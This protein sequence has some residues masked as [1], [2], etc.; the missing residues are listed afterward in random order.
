MLDL[1][2]LG[3]L[4]MPSPHLLVLLPLPNGSTTYNLEL[5]LTRI[6]SPLA[7]LPS[8]HAWPKQ[9]FHPPIN[10]SIDDHLP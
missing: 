8:H 2:H 9:A 6:H 5:L 4:A 3:L 10:N 7:H 1:L